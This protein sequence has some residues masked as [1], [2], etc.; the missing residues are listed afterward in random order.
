MSDVRIRSMLAAHET[1]KSFPF[2]PVE[3]DKGYAN[4]TLRIDLGKAD[5][6]IRPVT[7]Q[8][9]DLWVGGKGFDLWLMLQEINKNTRW[10]SPENAICFSPGPLAGTCSF[11]GS[12]KTLVTAVSPLTNII[13]DCNVGGYFGPFFKFAGFDALCMV[14]KSDDEVII[15]IDAI[16]KL[17]TIEKAPQE[18]VDSHLLA[19]ELTEMYADDELD[20]KNVAVVSAG[21]A[22]NHA[23]MGILNFSF[24]DWRRDCIRLKQAG[25]GGIGTVFRDKKIK[26]I[27]LKNRDI[28]PAWRIAENKVA[29][30]VTPKAIARQNDPKDIDGIKRI[31]DARKADPAHLMEMLTDIQA[32][33]NHVSKTAMDLLVKY[34]GI[35]LAKLYHIVTFY[36]FFS[37]E[38]RSKDSVP[39]SGGGVP[40][41]MVDLKYDFDLLHD[42]GTITGSGE[43]RPI[44]KHECVIDAVYAA[45]RSLSAESCGK[46]T[47]CREGLY[48]ASSLLAGICG[49]TGTAGDLSFLEE[50]AETMA[51][52]SQ[53]RF[54]TLSA[55]PILS[56]LRD[57]KT[58][59]EQHINEKKCAEGICFKGNKTGTAGVR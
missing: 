19:G 51:G 45:I 55:N 39:A 58:A 16:K 40:S 32:R 14:G 4:R 33:F 2:E 52:T 53:C 42:T 56:S 34:T 5:I 31:I 41:S 11:P 50:I 38:P 59:Y 28:T 44:K 23:W 29:K 27:V 9:K 26:A 8:M 12:G 1:L 57:F 49:G 7:Q 48:A 54:G 22:A 10:D 36:P 18:S 46:C 25:R 17:I 47:T 20:R 35:S 24:W 13:V 3:L 43:L 6:S 21:T 30:F 15:V 37:L